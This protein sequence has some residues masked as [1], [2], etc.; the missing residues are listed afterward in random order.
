MTIVATLNIAGDSAGTKKWPS[1][2]SIP[3]N[4]AATRDEHQE[5][6]HDAREIDRQ[7]ELAGHLRE[8]AGVEAHQ[9]LGEDDRER[10]RARR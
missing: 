1:E 6:R 4:T 9:R 3:M 8:V 10:R 7:L 5:R 2:F